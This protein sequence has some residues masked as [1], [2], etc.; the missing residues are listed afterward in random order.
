MTD[1]EIDIEIVENP[2][3]ILIHFIDTKTFEELP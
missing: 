2:K 1:N 3:R